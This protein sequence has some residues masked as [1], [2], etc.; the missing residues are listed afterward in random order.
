MLKRSS[1]AASLLVATLGS[2]ALAQPAYVPGVPGPVVSAS[3][4][5]V[6][7]VPVPMVP[8]GPPAT[9]VPPP[10]GPR[11]EC[12]VNVG[13]DL[14]NV[15][16]WPNGPVIGILPSGTPLTAL[17]F[18]GEW[19]FVQNWGGIGWVYGPYLACGPLYY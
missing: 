13:W 15:R 8:P 2:T 10:G 19:A 5:P 11:A 7:T 1:L 18:N 16:T 4:G 9:Y 12:I 14:L 17:A 6:V 3:V